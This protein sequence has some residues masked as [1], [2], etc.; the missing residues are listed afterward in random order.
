MTDRFGSSCKS[1]KNFSNFSESILKNSS[2]DLLSKDFYNHF[3][4]SDFQLESIIGEGGQ[5]KI[6]LATHTKSNKRCAVKTL[7][8]RSLFDEARNKQI[9][10]EAAIHS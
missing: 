7:I 4:K 3:Q 1:K 2:L 6:R 9:Q 5:A 8:K 10:Q